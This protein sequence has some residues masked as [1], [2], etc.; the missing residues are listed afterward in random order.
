MKSHH[1]EDDHQPGKGSE[2]HSGESQA[3]IRDEDTHKLPNQ[4]RQHG[5]EPGSGPGVERNRNQ[6]GG[7][8]K[9]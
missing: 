9:R 8:G 1:D 5:G 3:R 4:D 2:I 7:G 6:G